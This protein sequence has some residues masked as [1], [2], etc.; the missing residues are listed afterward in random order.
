[1]TDTK[2]KVLFENEA[3]RLTSVGLQQSNGLCA[4]LAGTE[5]LHITHPAAPARTVTIPEPPPGYPG[6]RSSLPV[7]TAMYNMAVRELRAN[8]HQGTLLLA[9]ANWSTVWTRDIAYAAA[10]GASLTEPSAVRNSLKSRV[11]DGIILQD[12]GTGGGWPISTDRVAWALGAWSLYQSTGDRD[13]LTYSAEV[14][15]N[16]LEQDA[17]LPTAANGLIPGETSF[18]DWREQSY[19]AHM[20]TAEI[21]ASYALSTNILHYAALRLTA[22]M[23]KELGNHAAATPFAQKAETLGT[24][25]QQHFWSRANM[26]YSMYLTA[27]GYAEDRVDSLATALAVFCGLTGE[28]NRRALEAIPRSPW[29]TPVFSPYKSDTPACYHNRAIWPFQEAFVMLAHAALGD[30]HGMAFSM[31]S[32]LRAALAFGTNKENFRADTGEAEGTLLN[33]DRQLW[34]VSGMLGMYF[35]GLFGIQYEHNCL[36]FSPCVPK[37]FAGSHWLTNLHIRNM[38]LNVHINGYGTDICS[39]MVNGKA[40]SPIIPLDTTGRVHVE[41][42]LLP[43]DEEEPHPHFPPAV[44]DLP[45]PQWD[46][47]TPER[48]SWHPVPGARAYYVYANGQA[49]GSVLDCCLCP[50]KNNTF[51]TSCRIQAIADARTSGF[52]S[53]YECPAPGARRILQP[54]RIGAEAEYSVEHQ[55]A[56]LDTHPYTARLDYESCTLAAGTYNIRIRYC[57][58][59]ASKR[60]GDTCA[61]R[62]L[63]VNEHCMGIIALPHNTEQG[64]WEDYTYTAA[65]PLTLEAGPH[66]FSLRYNPTTCTNSNSATNQCMVRELVLTRIG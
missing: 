12:T 50:P 48:L 18:I 66:H 39:V 46:A 11:K 45:T 9:G 6:M 40:A 19:P 34:S 16:T 26:Q 38:E 49:I 31:A 25:I 54:L 15:S 21:G 59:T 51:L 13:W 24:G 55:Q 37:A 52:S 36:V 8:M 56:W 32:M 64:C 14:L 41:I 42:E 5:Q 47:P 61:L 2:A 20:S 30:A 4:R 1:M 3:Y 43:E 65:L 44:E 23:L 28:H 63:L 35:Y 29:G 7:L 22:G 17:I 62:E 53:P 57:N 33:S 60:D 10:L 27:D 58:A